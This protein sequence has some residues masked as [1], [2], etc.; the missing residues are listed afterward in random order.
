[1]R[2]QGA[3]NGAYYGQGSNGRYPPLRGGRLLGVGAGRSEG[4]GPRAKAGVDTG[5]L[6]GAI[7]ASDVVPEAIRWRWHPYIPAGFCTIIEGDPGVGKPLL[8]CA[9]TAALSAGR[10]LPGDTA[11]PPMKVMILTQ[12]DTAQHVIQPRLKAQQANLGNILIND[13]PFYLDSQGIKRLESSIVRLGFDVVF[14]DPMVVYMEGGDPNKA[15]DVRAFLQPLREVALRTGCAIIV[16]RHLRKSETSNAKYKGA[17]S[18]DIGA[19]VRSALQ[20]S[21]VSSDT[22]EAE[23]IKHN[24]SRKGDTLVFH[25]GSNG[26]F[27]WDQPKAPTRTQTPQVNKTPRPQV[28]TPREFARAQQLIR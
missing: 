20:L 5:D 14:I 27:T 8:L 4:E 12:E 13:Q 26:G 6:D 16:V 19:A 18:I 10:A 2:A 1:P 23:H 28:N 21:E 9:V 3:A 7:W 15:K 17:G 22:V 11:R 24:F 25:K